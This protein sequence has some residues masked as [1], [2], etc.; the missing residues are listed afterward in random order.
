VWEALKIMEKKGYGKIMNIVRAKRGMAT[1][2]SHERRSDRHA[3]VVENGSAK[4]I[5]ILTK[6]RRHKTMTEERR[7]R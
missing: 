1:S 2:R 5:V 6:K 4:H 3:K 7:A